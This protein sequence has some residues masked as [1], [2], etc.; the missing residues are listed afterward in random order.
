MDKQLELNFN[1]IVEKQYKLFLSLNYGDNLKL[2]KSLV[3]SI[4]RLKTCKNPM[5]PKV[6][7]RIKLY[8]EILHYCNQK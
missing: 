5:H 7:D 8:T 2:A 6:Q 4:E 1:T 3:E